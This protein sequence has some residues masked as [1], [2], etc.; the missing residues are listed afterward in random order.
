[1]A[2][3]TDNGLWGSFPTAVGVE[4]AT[5]YPGSRDGSC[6]L[7]VDTASNVWLFGGIGLGYDRVGRLGDLW[8]WRPSTGQWYHTRLLHWRVRSLMMYVC[9]YVCARKTRSPLW[10]RGW[11][12]GSK[13]AEAKQTRVGARGVY[14]MEHWPFG[15]RFPARARSRDNILYIWGGEVDDWGQWMNDLY[16]T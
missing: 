15:R 1:M 12:A 9:M 4:G 14:S 8:R 7:V 5:Y 11:I 13:M 16:D 3:R 6:N 2:G 10:H